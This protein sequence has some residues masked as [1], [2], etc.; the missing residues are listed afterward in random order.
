[1]DNKLIQIGL[2]L[3]IIKQSTNYFVYKILKV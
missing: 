1:M 2:A 3:Q